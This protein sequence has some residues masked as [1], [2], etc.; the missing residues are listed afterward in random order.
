MPIIAMPDYKSHLYRFEELGSSN[1]EA[2]RECYVEGDWIVVEDQLQGRGQRGHTWLSGRGENLTATLRLE[3]RFLVVANQFLLSEVVA[4]ALCDM[5]SEYGIEAQIK[6]TNDIYVDGKKIAGVLI[7]HS[8]VSS[9]INYTVVG[10]GLN[11]NQKQFDH[12]LP[13]PTSMALVTGRDFCREEISQRLWN[14]LLRRYEE[15]RCCGGEAIERDYHSRLYRLNQEQLFRLASK[16]EFVGVIRGVKAQ[17]DL[18]IEHP[19][20]ELRHYLFREVE[21]VIEK[22]GETEK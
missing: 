22:K 3:P 14:S 15:L 11:I 19:D 4:L 18:L 17:G 7:E 12:S 5:L 8:L 1:D 9:G 16:E 20:Q 13:N 21:F 2:R 10:I 6:W